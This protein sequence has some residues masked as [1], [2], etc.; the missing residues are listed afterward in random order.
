MAFDRNTDAALRSAFAQLGVRIAPGA[1]TSEMIPQ[2]EAFQMK[3]STDEGLL[4]IR[5]HDQIISTGTALK[6]FTGKHPEHFVLPGGQVR[7]KDQLLPN[8]CKEGIRQRVEM[9][10]EQGL[11]GFSKIITNQSLRPGVVASREMSR[12]DWANLT[13]SEKVAAINAD[14]Q[15]ASIIMAQKR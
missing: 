7:S 14:P 11:D 6:A 4:V 8:D 3:V 9:I 5:Q 12:A 15:I 10:R 13:V 2:L 1:K